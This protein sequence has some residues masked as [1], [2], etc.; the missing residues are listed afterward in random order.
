[1][2]ATRTKL[3]CD[4]ISCEVSGFISFGGSREASDICAMLQD[5]EP[6]PSG[7]AQGQGVMM[8]LPASFGRGLEPASPDTVAGIWICGGN[9]LDRRHFGLVATNFEHHGP[10]SSPVG[11]IGGSE[12]GQTW[13]GWSSVRWRLRCRLE[14]APPLWSCSQIKAAASRKSSYTV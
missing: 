2:V 4:V 10:N 7:F 3:T 8:I 1:M 13:C 6:P 5:C 9:S 14:C 12:G 11:M